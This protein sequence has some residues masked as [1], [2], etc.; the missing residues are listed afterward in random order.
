LASYWNSVLDRRISRR[1][2][3]AATS[4]GALGAAFLAACGGDDGDG[5]GGGGGGSTAPQSNLPDSI[6][7][8]VD[9]SKSAKRGGVWKSYLV[10]DPQNFD[11]YNFDP[12]R[13]HSPTRSARSL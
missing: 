8:P 6:L 2:A 7:K 9:T 12:F 4:A 1:R 5:G 11:L 13:S 10:R 3:I